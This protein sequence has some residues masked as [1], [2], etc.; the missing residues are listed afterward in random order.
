MAEPSIITV[1][2][3]LTHFRSTLQTARQTGEPVTPA[4][5]AAPTG[6]G[7]GVI[8]LRRRTPAGV[9]LGYETWQAL[10]ASQPPS[11]ADLS[12]LRAELRSVR[13]NNSVLAAD[14]AAARQRVADLE[15]Q[16]ARPQPSAEVGATWSV[17]PTS[18]APASSPETGLSWGSTAA[19]AAPTSPPPPAI[20]G[21][22]RS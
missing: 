8:A 10:I 16:L 4:P 21:W 5:A 1:R 7:A 15:A 12:A 9:L 17:T 3:L 19:P 14:L 11:Q 6:A 18:A 2:T 20:S 13:Q 22:G